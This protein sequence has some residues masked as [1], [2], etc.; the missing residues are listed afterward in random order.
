[1]IDPDPP[2]SHI[3]APIFI[4]YAREDGAW[5]EW[6]HV[7]LVGE[8]FK[9]IWWDTVDIEGGDRWREEIDRGLLS[10][11]IVLVV[12]TP[13]SVNPDRSW[14]RYEQDEALRL[15]RAVIPILVEPCELPPGMPEIQ[16]L[17]FSKDREAKFPALITSIGKFVHRPGERLADQTPSHDYAFVGRERELT[18]LV[19]LLER[20][21]RTTTGRLSIAIQGMGGTG[22]TMVANELAR[23][24]A[25]RYPGGVITLQ[26]GQAD[27]QTP[28]MVL[29]TW[30]ELSLRERPTRQWSPADLRSYLH[31]HHGEILVIID[32]VAEADFG[33]VQIL[34]DSMPPDA[35]RLV[36][37]RSRIFEDVVG[38][39]LFSLDQLS[40][41][42]G[43][44]LLRKRMEQI[45]G[46]EPDRALL[47]RFVV[48]VGGHALSLH[49]VAGRCEHVRELPEELELLEE[50]LEQGDVELIDL[51][52]DVPSGDEEFRK[53]TSVAA[54]LRLSLRSLEQQVDKHG[55]PYSERFIATGVFPNGA[56]ITRAMAR[57]AWGLEPRDRLSDVVLKKLRQ[58]SV[59]FQDSES[60]HYQHHP[61][62]RSYAF[63]LLNKD[64]SAFEAV[65]DRYAFYVTESTREQTALPP[66]EWTEV[67]LL[68][69]HLQLIGAT[70]RGRVQGVL[71]AVDSWVSAV[72]TAV[73]PGEMTDSNKKLLDKALAFSDVASTLTVLR[74]ELGQTGLEWLQL[75][76]ASARALE[77]D[78][79]ALV[80][81]STLAAWYERRKP[82]VAQAYAEEALSLARA[83]G[84]RPAEASV[85]SHL[86]ELNRTQGRAKEAKELLD[87]ALVAHRE[88]GNA[89]MQAVTLKYLG[90]T[91]WRLGNHDQ[92]L[93]LQKE[94]HALFESM[95]DK[96]GV[97]DALNKI[98]SVYFNSGDHRTAIG[99]FEDALAIHREVGNKSMQ[100]EDLNDMGAA[101]KYLGD[102]DGA[103]SALFEALVLHEEVG[104]R[105][106]Q[107]LTK[108]NISST[109][110]LQ[111]L[112]EQGVAMAEDALEI[113][114]DADEPVGQ[115]W[116]LMWLGEASEE[117]GDFEAARGHWEEALG[118]ARRA[119][120]PRGEAGILGNLG[121]LYW[122]RFGEPTT[123]RDHLR[124]AVQL[125]SQKK[126]SQ[127]L[128]GRGLE[129]M[130]SLLAEVEHE[131]KAEPPSS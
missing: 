11:Y 94:S 82:S 34:L 16:Y 93:S 30:A 24:L 31:E 98:G 25:I 69:P 97:G 17:D 85:L 113:S 110:L 13:H 92:A 20:K 129:E 4:S 90:E 9:E 2:P 28:E 5:V 65:F 35:T 75:G 60:G 125:M 99:Y 36:T 120:N 40:M 117:V 118:G 74:P 42:D 50:A 102:L 58:K 37:T 48:A 15:F 104:N 95:G 72:P 22:K 64:P 33:N 88:L 52:F 106:L 1:M 123:G 112:R 67:E 70:F 46:G 8:G 44:A 7:R 96:S 59:I 66:E 43:I 131:L 122:K 107:A 68:I 19:E 6:L 53:R 41:S 76:L 116:A 79:S 127:A 12:L 61:I 45:K 77:N 21:A 32:D 84:D 108:A 87:Q 126:L 73:V 115:S 124:S 38:G 130:K 119:D 3:H 29:Q 83:L 100:A 81:L 23:R 101:K 114:R 54:N 49:L 55:V 80:F 62:V 51:D 10:S 105:R 86:G 121:V 128:G 63:G 39:L 89:R 57:A 27:K 18:Q 91:H 14:I 78:P 47:E 56:L 26:R 109:Y 103:L 111:G 71:G